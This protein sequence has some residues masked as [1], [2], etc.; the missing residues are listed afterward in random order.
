MESLDKAKLSLRLVGERKAVD[1]LLFQVKDFTSY[2][3]Y[4]L[5]AGGTSSRQVQAIA[6]HLQKKMREAGFRP[7]GVEGEEVG[8]WVL[9]DYGDVVV[10]IFYQPVREFYDLEGLWIEAPRVPAEDGS[11]KDGR[12]VDQA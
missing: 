12:L 9:V 5:I 1:P 3:D 8:Q 7:Y 11:G 4:L 10:H 2:T 6:R